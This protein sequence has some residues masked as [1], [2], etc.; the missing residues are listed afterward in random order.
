MKVALNCDHVF[1]ILTRGPFPTGADH[2]ADVEVHLEACH[3]C[4]RLAE[5]LRPAVSLFHEALS[6]P[7]QGLP[8]FRGRIKVALADKQ[9]GTVTEAPCHDVPSSRTPY[10][11]ALVPLVLLVVSA[12]F[13]WKAEHPLRKLVWASTPTAEP[14]VFYPDATGGRLLAA[15]GMPANCL[16]VRTDHGSRN[17]LPASPDS[18][19]AYACCSECHTAALR[20]RPPK[21]AVPKV[22]AACKACHASSAADKAPCVRRPADISAPCLACHIQVG[23]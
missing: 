3:D 18:R 13:V 23:H 12:T 7:Q 16:P 21:A 11:L 19:A 17:L 20:Q 6:G 5:M 4:R 9:F 22:S 2:D 1:D 8:E 15:L 14:L 10:V